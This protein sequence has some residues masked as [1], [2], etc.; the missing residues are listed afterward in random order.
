[1]KVN[2]KQEEEKVEYGFPIIMEA[3][4]TGLIVLFTSENVG[5]VIDG[6]SSVWSLGEH[7]TDWFPNHDKIHWKKFTGTITL[8]ND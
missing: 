2:V 1:M 6:G 8:G 7:C 4:R 3:E 5:V